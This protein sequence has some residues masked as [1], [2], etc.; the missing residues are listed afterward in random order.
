MS[1]DKPDHAAPDL[2]SSALFATHG[3][4]VI[5]NGNNGHDPVAS[6]P[7]NTVEILR[8]AKPDKVRSG[9]PKAQG[10]KSS[11]G[12]GGDGTKSN[13]SKGPKEKRPSKSKTSKEIGTVDG[14]KDASHRMPESVMPESV[15]PESV[16]PESVM[17]ESV[18]PASV[19]PESVLELLKV[20]D[21]VPD[22]GDGGARPPETLGSP[23][24]QPASPGS[25]SPISFSNTIPE[26]G[27][28]NRQSNRDA[29]SFVRTN[30]VSLSLGMVAVCLAVALVV[31]MLELGIRNSQL[32]AKNA[33]ETART[34]ALAAA[35]TYSVELA[36]YSYQH[37]DQDF[38]AVM[39]DSTPSWQQSYSKASSALKSIL[40]RFNSS[41]QATLLSAG[42]VTA[43][44]TRAVAV[45]FLEQT[46]TNATQ[47]KPSSSRT[48]L[49]MT[50]DYSHGKWLID[51]VTVF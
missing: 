40:I 23:V 26:E 37:L 5:T 51:D 4:Q 28:R 50:L 11:A 20:K 9:K 13:G 31:T 15:M 49:E 12:K 47:K 36:S 29:K 7:E 30:V 21:P 2:G 35:R 41:A 8:A 43:T 24:R 17:P 25:S 3:S 38:A 22:L 33:L 32:A 48:Q 27:E 19:M 1:D 42:L 18:K 6:D 16:M 34:T 45:V 39:A 46:V 44:T 14:A 10:Y